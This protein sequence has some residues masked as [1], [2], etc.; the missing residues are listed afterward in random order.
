M[1][2]SP[3]ERNPKH[4]ILCL[5]L[6]FCNKNTV[7]GD[8]STKTGLVRQPYKASVSGPFAIINPGPEMALPHF[9]LDHSL[10]M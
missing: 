1:K 8:C 5:K 10:S 3:D 4:A 6:W 7:S 2:L 9:L